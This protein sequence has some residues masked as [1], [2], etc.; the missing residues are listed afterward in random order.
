MD[1]LTGLMTRCSIRKYQDAPISEEDIRTML[2]AAMCA[3]TARRQE[4]WSFVTV[5]DKA[6]LHKAAEVCPNAGMAKHAPLGVLVCADPRLETKSP[7]YWPQ[8]CAAATQNLLLAAHGLG[9]GAVWTAAYFREDRMKNYR[10]LFNIPEEIMPFAFI[11][12]GRPAEE[13]GE[14]NRWREDRV[15]VNGW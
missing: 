10:E 9:L 12:I 14:K 11:V 2:E 6:L 5:T 15:H 3:P 4:P 7:G 8:D 13:S 1:L